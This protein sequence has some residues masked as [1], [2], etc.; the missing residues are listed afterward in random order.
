MTAR[1]WH[2]QPGET[3][4]AFLAFVTYRDL[5]PERTVQA[6]IDTSNKTSSGLHRTWTGW[7]ARHHWVQRAAA[8]DA[9]LDEVRLNA[10][11]DR[12]ARTTEKHVQAA[13]SLIDKGLE[14]LRSMDTEDMTPGD[15]RMYVA[16]G[17]KL[18]RLAMGLSTENC[19]QEVNSTVCI[20]AGGTARRI[21][22]DPVAAQLACDLIE[23]VGPGPDD[24]S[25][26]R[27]PRVE[28]PL[29]SGEA[30]GSPQS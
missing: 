29:E 28:R 11:E 19:K 30:P 17:I 6:A 14:H 5:G 24:P 15:V 16:D 23:R 10:I 18:Q 8:Y 7:S 2:R 9:H 3:D 27:D 20:D 22:E 26:V 25:W 12:V 13:Q 4:K 21:L 1:P